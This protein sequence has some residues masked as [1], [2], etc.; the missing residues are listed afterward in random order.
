MLTQLRSD[1]QGVDRR[2]VAGRLELISRWL[3]SD[4]SIRA[5]LGQAMVA[6]EEGKRAVDLA[7]AT[8]EVALRDAEDAKERCQVAGAE[9]ESLCNERDVEAHQH[10]A[11]ED[12][13]K[14]REDA[15]ADRDTELEQLE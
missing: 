11:Q 1:L 10:G 3:R 15:V 12:K 6:S 7:A 13:L 5:A 2:L 4:A 14:T 9:L 8:R